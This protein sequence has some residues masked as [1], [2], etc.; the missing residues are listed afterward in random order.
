MAAVTSVKGIKMQT[1][2]RPSGFVLLPLVL[3]VS[4]AS[5]A[6]APAGHG[7]WTH[8][9]GVT[10]GNEYDDN[11]FAERENR[12]DDTITVV[13]PFAELV[14][15]GERHEVRL[16]GSAERGKYHAFQSENYT[17]WRLGTEGR[18]AYGD[19][20]SIFGGLNAG[21]GHESRT[22]P[23]DVNG[24]EPTVYDRLGAFAGVNHTF[25][26]VTSRVGGTWESLDFDDVEAD[27]GFSIEQDDRDRDLTTFGARIGYRVSKTLEP[28]VQAAV[29]LREYDRSSESDSLDRDS[30][31]ANAAVGLITRPSPSL[32]AEVLVGWMAQ[33]YD[34]D[35]LESPP[36]T[37]HWR[38]SPSTWRCWKPP[39]ATR[40]P[41]ATPCRSPPVPW[42]T[43]PRRPSP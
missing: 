15:E 14:G 17:D 23:D 43:T 16:Y 38:T 40:R 25:G 9:A 32:K 28:F 3:A 12:Q 31:G 13:S 4:S 1:R 8:D 2:N 29:D 21:H 37:R 30:Q 42:A 6:Q 7:D 18:F 22:S 41:T 19:A 36:S 34:G 20:G 39:A 11:I 35:A 26:R 10:V 33:D 27:G 24:R 5:Q